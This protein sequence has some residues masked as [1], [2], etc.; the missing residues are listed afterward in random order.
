[1][2]VEPWQV[3]MCNFNPQVGSEQPGARPAIVV[4]SR[5]HA[6]LGWPL[7]LV[8]PTTTQDKGLGYHVPLGVVAG[9]RRRRRSFAICEQITTVSH[10]RLVRHIGRLS[11]DQIAN[12]RDVIGRM[13]D[14]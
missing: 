10:Q 14:L 7:T 1:M 6:Q 3:W 2:K 9:D 4:A 11:P 13:I 8:V 12:V 5:L